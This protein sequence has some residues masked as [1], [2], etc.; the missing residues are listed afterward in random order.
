M[1]GTLRGA[2]EKTFE[3]ISGKGKL[4]EED[5]KAAA[6]EI[7]LSL[8]AADVHYSVVK[9]F[10]DG[11]SEKAVGKEV[12]QSITPLQQF[13]KIVHDELVRVLGE[14]QESFDFACKPPLIVL[15]VGLQG[16]GKTTT[17][18]RFAKL[19]KEEG[20]R[21]Y[22]VPA[23]V[24]RPAAIQQ[25]K[26]LAK[27]AG[28]DVWPTEEG[29]RA[30]KVA[31]KAVKHADK[32]GYDT[33]IIDTAGRLH[34]DEEMMDEV[35]SIARKVEPQRIL[36]VADAMTGQDAVKSAAAFNGALEITGVVLSKLDGD[37]RG[38]AALSVRAVTGKPI[39]FAG[40]GE[41]IDDIEPFYPDRMAGR[42]LGKGDIVSLVEKVAGE[43]KE[44]EAAQMEATFRK[45]SFSFDDYLKQLKMVGR[46]GPL[47]KML[48][49]IPGLS[50][51]S[52]SI[53]T[54]DLG[55]EL[56]RKEA[57]IQSMTHQERKNPKILNGSR[58]KRIAAGSGVGVNDLNRLIKEYGM[59]AKMMRKAAKGGL[60]N[61][62]KGL[63]PQAF[64]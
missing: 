7:K 52:G 48:G 61:L 16:S 34:I 15:I 8:L 23:D 9:N 36:Y 1:F 60:K 17:A 53:N 29:D 64:S 3:K 28:V 56:R 51:M 13:T 43:V 32:N 35:K 58:R 24:Y 46:M 22:L 33:V 50:A 54:D 55:R 59:F 10:V 19:C 30:V 6:R 26:I 37:A 11:I 4:R 14:E 49:M 40:T 44:E 31:R 12:L 20:R 57:M 27:S 63:T 18:A 41:S 21:P 5:V 47:D 25:L 38:G 62:F 39:I 45:G 2:F 42:I